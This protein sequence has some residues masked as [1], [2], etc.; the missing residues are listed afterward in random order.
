MRGRQ[1]P[2]VKE[3]GFHAALAV[4]Q[5]DGRLALW[6]GCFIWAGVVQSASDLGFELVNNDGNATIYVGDHGK[7]AKAVASV[8][9]ANKNVIN[10]RFSIK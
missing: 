9:P 3:I 1:R 7:P 8:T 6:P 5:I 10:V 2:G 4:H